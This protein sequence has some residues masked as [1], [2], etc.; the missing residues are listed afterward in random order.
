MFLTNNEKADFRVELVL[1]NGMKSTGY[2]VGSDNG[3]TCQNI[4]W[5]N[6]GRCQ[7]TQI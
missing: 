5:G 6:L 3:V 2:D 7:S 4:V 1:I